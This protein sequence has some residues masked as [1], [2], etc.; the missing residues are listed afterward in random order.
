MNQNAKRKRPVDETEDHPS[1]SKKTKMNTISPVDL[2]REKEMLNVLDSIRKTED[3]LEKLQIYED[4]LMKEEAVMK[5]TKQL[6]AV[7]DKADEDLNDLF[8]YVETDDIGRLLE[9]IN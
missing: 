5:M 4:L 3:S 9:Y 2:P 8:E 1:T 6:A 7:R